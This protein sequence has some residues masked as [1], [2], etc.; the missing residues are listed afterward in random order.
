LEKT[1]CKQNALI[2]YGISLESNL[3]RRPIMDYAN[4]TY[5]SNLI[6]AYRELLDFT[7]TLDDNAFASAPLEGKWSPA[8]HLVHLNRS[9]GIVVWVSAWPHA[10]KRLL[11]GRSNRPSR[12]YDQLVQRYQER[13]AGIQAKSPAFFAPPPQ[14]ASQ[15]KRI[16][17]RLRTLTE[18][19][20]HQ[21]RSCPP[22]YLESQLL[23]HPA[24]GKVTALEMVLFS[25][26][27]GRLH[28][29]LMQRDLKAKGLNAL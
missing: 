5:E 1:G 20:A 24:L 8:Q 9:L 4:D 11:W 22:E 2:E 7:D 17:A 23:P 26:Y 21:L 3:P 29:G 16:T 10:L 27:H 15:R 18:R 28:L 19:Y 13:L 14:K 6:Q 12:S 25:A